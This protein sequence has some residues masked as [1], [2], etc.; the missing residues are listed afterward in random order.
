MAD[1]ET[2]NR[3]RNPDKTPEP[4]AD[5]NAEPRSGDSIFVIQKHDA[6]NLHY[7]FRLQVGNALKSW[8]V[9]K[10]PS[11]DPRDK[12]L[13]IATEDHPLEYAD[14][15]GVIP[16]GEYGGGS[17]I[18]WD[19]GTY[20]HRTEKDGEKID[21]EDA[22]EKGHISV[23]LHGEKLTGGYELIKMKGKNWSKDHWL[24][25]KTD[26]DEADA[27]RNPTSTQPKSVISGK[28]VE[29]VAAEEQS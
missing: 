8:A 5:P 12:Q 13:A 25:K 11:T 29:E 6:S 21:Y 9:P 27:R 23:F 3:K 14:F 1:L 2:Y 26:D 4:V 22:E 15:E 7:D 28:T 17:V 18:V 19:H 10:G 20:E 24:L 16:E